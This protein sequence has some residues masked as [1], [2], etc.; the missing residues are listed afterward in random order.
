MANTISIHDVI[1]KESVRLIKANCIIA[2]ICDTSEDERTKGE[3]PTWK[4]AKP[5]STMRFLKPMQIRGRDG[6]NLQVEP[7]EEE[8]AVLAK[9]NISGADLEVNI[10]ELSDDIP[11]DPDNIKMFSDDYLN[12]SMQ[13]VGARIDNRAFGIMY[14]QIS[15]VVNTFGQKLSS[16][17]IMGEAQAK[18]R[19]NECPDMPDK[20]HFAITSNGVQEWNAA[21]GGSFNPTGTISDQYTTGNIGKSAGFNFHRT[22]RVKIHT[23]GDFA[24][25]G[26]NITV[27]TAPTEGDDTLILQG[28]TAGSVLTAG[29]V[30]FFEDTYMLNPLTY[31]NRGM[32]QGFTLVSDATADGSGLM[33]IQTYQDFK[34]DPTARQNISTLPQAGDIVTIDGSPLE[35]SVQNI[36]MHEYAF[37]FGTTKLQNIYPKATGQDLNIYDNESKFH[38]KFTTNGQINDLTAV[39]RI[40]VAWGLGEYWAQWACRVNGEW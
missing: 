10:F 32:L 5:G 17:A 22:E 24:L 1:S 31:E 21:V 25:S 35:R 6:I 14:P 16:N 33:S 11:D 39:T 19:Q 20:M 8:D 29:T 9:T 26:A 36:A 27:Q 18:L 4:G 23:H 37:L 3:T 28:F 15:N 38:M 7:I 40:D 30:I 13:T 2:N 12:A 34:S